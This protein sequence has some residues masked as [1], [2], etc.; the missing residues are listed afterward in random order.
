MNPPVIRGPYRRRTGR[1]P[2]HK[3]RGIERRWRAG[4]LDGRYRETQQIEALA[5]DFAADAGGWAYLTNREVALIHTAAFA[6]WVCQATAVWA[7][8]RDGGPINPDGTVPAVLGKTFVAYSN[9]LGR[10][11]EKLGLRPDRAD[12]VPSLPEYLASKKNGNGTHANGNQA[13]ATEPPHTEGTVEPVDEQ[14][15]TQ[16][17]GDSNA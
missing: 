3:V 4:K 13:A 7:L 9:T 11:L 1:K 5:D 16:D 6:A 10:T 15:A 12:K 8:R 2:T 14:N 17:A